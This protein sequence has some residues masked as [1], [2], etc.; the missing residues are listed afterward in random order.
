MPALG[1]P[2]FGI[3]PLCRACVSPAIGV[4]LLLAASLGPS[5]CRPPLGIATF[6]EPSRLRAFGG[7]TSSALS[8][9][10]PRRSAKSRSAGG[11]LD[12]R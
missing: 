7:E 12:G 8:G 5:V 10:T 9:S 6:L 1:S 2:A 11:R 3:T 4:A